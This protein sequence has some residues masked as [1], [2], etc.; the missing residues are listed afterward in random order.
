MPTGRA[1]VLPWGP[2][3]AHLVLATMC[4]CVSSGGMPNGASRLEGEFPPILI[5]AMHRENEKLVP[6]SASV[7]EECLNRLLLLIQ[8]LEG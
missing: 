4:L 3:T 1:F 6:T 8:K 7:S 2:G 5:L